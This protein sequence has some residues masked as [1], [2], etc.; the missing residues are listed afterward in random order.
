MLT[1]VNR[2]AFGDAFVNL[3]NDEHKL[4][5]RCVWNGPQ[6]IASKPALCPIYGHELSPLFRDVL[7]ISNT[8][9]A[10]ARA[11]L[12]QLKDDESTTMADVAEVYVFLHKYRMTT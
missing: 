5:S 6:G 12:E 11:H 3:A 1:V 9:S 4:L 2:K 8:T 7:E 10:Q